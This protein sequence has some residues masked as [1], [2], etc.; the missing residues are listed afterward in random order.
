MRL[1]TDEIR[2]D[3]PAAEYWHLRLDNNFDRFCASANKSTFQLHSLREGSDEHGLPTV[4]CES[5]VHA[6]SRLPGC[7]VRSE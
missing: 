4:V 1:I 7:A 2:I 3:M 6:G 5:E